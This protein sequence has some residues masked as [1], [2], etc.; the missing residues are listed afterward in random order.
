MTLDPERPIKGTPEL[1]TKTI[2]SKTFFACGFMQ[3]TFPAA[4]TIKTPLP[5][6]DGLLEEPRQRP[7]PIGPF[8]SQPIE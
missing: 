1:I 3:F 2:R 6:P 5:L 7:L 4:L 8:P